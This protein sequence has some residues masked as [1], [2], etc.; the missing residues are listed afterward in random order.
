MPLD[1]TINFKI[2]V[3]GDGNGM[4]CIQRINT[5]NDRVV[6]RIVMSYPE[7]EAMALQWEAIGD[8]AY[9][10]KKK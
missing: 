6:E 9:G 3:H 1:I 5:L 4:V 2:R 8:E 7:F 10:V